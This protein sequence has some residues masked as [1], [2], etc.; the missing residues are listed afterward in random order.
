MMMLVRLGNLKGGRGRL[1]WIG[2]L[3]V[4]VGPWLVLIWLLWPR[5]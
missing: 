3:V 1:S 2:F 5:R 4:T